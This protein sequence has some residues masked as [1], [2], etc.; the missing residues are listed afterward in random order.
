MFKK[1]WLLP[2]V[3]TSN[4]P[5][6]FF[7]TKTDS[8]SRKDTFLSLKALFD[9]NDIST[10]VVLGTCLGFVRG[11]DFIEYDHDMDFAFYEDDIY[12]LKNLVS[13]LGELGFFI[14][15][16]CPCNL[17]IQSKYCKNTCD[18]WIIHKVKNPIYRL[19]GYKWLY[20]NGF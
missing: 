4:I 18:L 20:N 14:E 9:S 7:E 15:E 2:S 13:Q 5:S 12:K 19:L 6:D 11:Q 10:F 17:R 1:K 3:F 8:V 16:V